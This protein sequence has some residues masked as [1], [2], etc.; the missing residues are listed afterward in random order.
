MEQLPTPAFLVDESALAKQA[1]FFRD[2]MAA[3]W[4]TGIVSYSVKTNS[5]PWIVAWMA[6]NGV[7][8]EVVSDHEY[9]L[10]RAL[11]HRPEAI[12]FN[13][14]VKSREVVLGALADGALI[15]IDSRREIRWVLEHASAHPAGITSVGIR[16]NWDV[17]SECPG[18]TASGPAGLRFG[19]HIDNDL[20]DA[21]DTLTRAGVRI[22]GLHLHVT[23][24]GREIAVY[25]SAASTVRRILE[26]RPL[27]LDYIDIGGGFFGGDDPHFPTPTEYL[28]AIRQE[29]AGP[30]SP[31]DPAHTRL[32]IEPGAALVAVAVELHTGVIDTKPAGTSRIV[33]TDGSRTNI[34]P[35][36]RKSSYRYRIQSAGPPSTERQIICGFTC[37]DNDRLMTLEDAP[38]MSEGD[39]IIFE[40]VGSYT[41]CF[42][43]LFIN[44]FPAT[45]VR[46][47]DGTM[48]V[49][50]EPWELSQYLAR[51]DW[52]V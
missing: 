13:G 35:F 5:L 47:E 33:V 15:N 19:F 27:I 44:L 4:P 22:S 29:L 45:Y 28:L 11:G 10:A 42:N 30:G 51:N 9:E 14:P 8:A 23:S 41:M 50:R 31:I 52:T 18:A 16:V 38:S 25:R 12:V 37:L 49:T 20:W 2:A 17:E 34:D 46:H 24:L 48:V 21:I 40:A 7:W 26:Q 6:R 39:R 36:F 3:V 1:A 32:I 43:P